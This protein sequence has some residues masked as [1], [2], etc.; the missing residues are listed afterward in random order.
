MARALHELEMPNDRKSDFGS[1]WHNS[2]VES[3]HKQTQ[4]SNFYHHVGQ[5]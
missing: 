5:E 2:I 4:A 3:I 1:S